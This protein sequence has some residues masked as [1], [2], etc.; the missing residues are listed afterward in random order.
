[1]N[2][3]YSIMVS[4]ITSGMCLPNR[5]STSSGYESL[6]ARI[7]GD[8]TVKPADNICT[9][10]GKSASF[11]LHQAVHPPLLRAAIS[12]SKVPVLCLRKHGV[13]YRLGNRNVDRESD[14]VLTNRFLL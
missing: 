11:G 7:Y 13:H 9:P 1:M 5:E 12:L 14:G 10:K 6:I 8:L 2:F 4:A 3:Q